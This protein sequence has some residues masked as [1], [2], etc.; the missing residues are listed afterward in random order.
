MKYIGTSTSSQKMKNRMRSSA[1]NEPFIPVSSKRT[2][3]KN[4]LGLPGAGMCHQR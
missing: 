4:A 3:A 1:T 2:R